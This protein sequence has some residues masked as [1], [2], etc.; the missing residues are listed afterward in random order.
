MPVSGHFSRDELLTPHCQLCLARAAPFALKLIESLPIGDDV[1]WTAG[2]FFSPSDSAR[3][4]WTARWAWRTACCRIP[5]FWR[6]VFRRR[7]PA[8][9]FTPRKFSPQARQRFR[10]FIIATLIGVW[11]HDWESPGF[12]APSWAHGF[13]R[14]LKSH[15]RGVSSMPICS[16]WVSTS[17]GSQRESRWRRANPPVGW[18]CSDLPADFLMRVVEAGGDQ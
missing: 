8:R 2:G 15:P 1:S 17:Y 13:C 16:S 11:W 4:S 10:T 12:L 9:S 5:R 18:R 3:N 14:T 7:T 6:L